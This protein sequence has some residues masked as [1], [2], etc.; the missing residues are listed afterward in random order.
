MN[1]SHINMSP[2]AL[3]SSPSFTASHVSEREFPS[4]VLSH[5]PKSI[6][7]LGTVLSSQ[8]PHSFRG[9][10]GSEIA[11]LLIFPILFVRYY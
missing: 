8:P 4:R 6:I 7:A 10:E 9:F 3:V 2:L 11:A 5:V 1:V